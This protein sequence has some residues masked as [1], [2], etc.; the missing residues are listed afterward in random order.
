MRSWKEREG[1]Q[2]P[3]ATATSSTAAEQARGEG[4]RA[5]Q[6]AKSTTRG[7]RRK[8]RMT[9]GNSHLLACRLPLPVC[10]PDVVWAALMPIVRSL[11]CA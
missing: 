8:K 4:M 10:L 1:N 5:L 11:E 6:V 7:I 2:S 9:R 3:A